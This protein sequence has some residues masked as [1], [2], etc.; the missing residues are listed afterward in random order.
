MPGNN[1]PAWK[2]GRALE[3]LALLLA[4]EIIRR[5]LARI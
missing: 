4:A 2:S 3:P 1:K 5:C